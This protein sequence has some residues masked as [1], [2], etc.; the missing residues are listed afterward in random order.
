MAVDT[1]LGIKE[2][3]CS[4]FEHTLLHLTLLREDLSV[5]FGLHIQEPSNFVHAVTDG[6][7]AQRSGLKRYDRIVAVEGEALKGPIGSKGLQGKLC[8]S[9]D[10][11]RP[12]PSEHR[13]IEVRLL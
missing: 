3:S 1:K 9:V 8:F 12:A 2:D 7:P 4:A 13:N 5:P 11:E 10:V 6:S